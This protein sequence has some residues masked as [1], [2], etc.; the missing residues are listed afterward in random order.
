MKKLFVIKIFSFIFLKKNL[1]QT[2]LDTYQISKVFLLLSFFLLSKNH[3]DN[4]PTKCPILK[5]VILPNFTVNTLDS[6]LLIIISGKNNN[7]ILL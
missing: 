4:S 7:K 3:I 6:I 2:F 1:L 5:G